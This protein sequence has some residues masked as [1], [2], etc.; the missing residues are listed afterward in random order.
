M[1]LSGL[2]KVVICVFRPGES[3]LHLFET[4]A[5]SIVLDRSDWGLLSSISPS[6]IFFFLFS[7]MFPGHC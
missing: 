6:Q 5:L 3:A 2:R 7:K 1:I 4:V